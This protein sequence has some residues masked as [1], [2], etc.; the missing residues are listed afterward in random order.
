[1]NNTT[2]C[3]F[4]MILPTLTQPFDSKSFDVE[5][6]NISSKISNTLDGSIKKKLL[7]LKQEMDLLKKGEP[8][9]K[10]QRQLKAFKD[11][12]EYSSIY[13]IQEALNLLSALEDCSFLQ[14]Q[15]EL[16]KAVSSLL[17]SPI[18][19]GRPFRSFFQKER[20]RLMDSADEAILLK[21]KQAVT[22]DLKESLIKKL[23]NELKKIKVL[24]PYSNLQNTHQ[25][26]LSDKKTKKT[27]SLIDRIKVLEQEKAILLLTNKQC[28]ST[29]NQKDLLLAQTKTPCLPKPL[30][31]A[32]N[33]LTLIQLDLLMAPLEILIL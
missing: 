7:N 5:L 33:Q 22:F 17:E 30:E 24:K 10:T 14:P 23:L 15:P 29:Q 9:E 19:L 16:L 11:S 18:S 2:L 31:S 6:K 28:V 26:Y 21:T 20:A 27:M 8:W 1:M 32:I 4:L 3:L 13:K 12:P 25:K